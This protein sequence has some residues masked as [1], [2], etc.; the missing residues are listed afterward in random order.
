MVTVATP[1]RLALPAVRFARANPL[2]VAAF[3]AGTGLLV[4]SIANAM[5]RATEAP[6][7]LIYWVGILLIALPIFFRLTSRDASPGERLALV[8]LLGLALYGVKLV[9]DAP[10]FSFSDE[11]IHAYNSNEISRHHHMFHANPVLEVSRYYPGLEGA[12]SALRTLTGMSSFGAGAIVIA[13]ARLTMMSALF[14]VFWRVGKSDRIAGLGAAIFTGNFNF[15]YWS[16]QFSYESLSLPLLMIVVLLVVE[17]DL[18]RPAARGAWRLLAAIVMAAIVV[19]HHITSYALVITLAG[20]SLATALARGTKRRISP[21]PLALLALAM[22]VFWL[23]V[24]A[25][26]T[27]GYLSPVLDKALTSTLHTAAGEAPARQLFQG[28]DVVT[29]ATPTPARV[30]SLLAV[31][32]LALGLPFGLRKVW[33]RYRDQPVAIV[34]AVAAVGFFAAL[35]LRLAPDAWETGNRASEFLFI[36]LAFVL[37]CGGLELWRPLGRP[38][39]GRALATAALAIVLAG[40]AITGWPW[41]SQLSLPVRAEAAGGG[42]IH[43]PPLGMAEWAQRHPGKGHFA[44]L[45]SDSRL[46][47]DPA[48]RFVLTE[49]GAGV[50]EIIPA[51]ELPPGAVAL[52]RKQGARYVVADQRL[53]ADDG[54]RGYYFSIEGSSR[55]ELGPR[56]S[57]TKFDGAPGTTRI[58]DGGPIVVFDLKGGPRWLRRGGK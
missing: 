24:V 21:W 5:A 36:G 15:L 6:S 35:A 58:F 18:A 57:V 11:F 43:S 23:F 47:L 54:I 42:T 38:W 50:R 40:G 48:D 3:T 19:T 16:A 29:G 13:A 20:I 17:L 4:C 46:L 52:M 10:L 31:A 33:K 30:V 41:D 39:L 44:A 45:T 34:F 27:V 2:A 22:T 37:A 7:P 32:L 8:C 26:S 12:T 25:S 9:R 1:R 28:N 51:T 53:I 56:A 55:N 49:Y 14:L